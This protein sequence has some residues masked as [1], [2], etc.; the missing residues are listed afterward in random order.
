MYLIMNKF[1]RVSS[2]QMV[3]KS[4]LD[5]AIFASSGLVP[6]MELKPEKSSH[7]MGKTADLTLIDPLQHRG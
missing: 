5:S 1:V 6:V 7:N 4:I 2:R 3:N